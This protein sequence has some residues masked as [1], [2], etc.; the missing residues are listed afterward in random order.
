MD[1][2]RSNADAERLQSDFTPHTWPDDLIADL[3][4]C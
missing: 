2:Q 1:I 3:N 4:L